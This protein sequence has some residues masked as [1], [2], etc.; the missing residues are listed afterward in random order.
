VHAP[1]PER[2]PVKTA[3][4]GE[5]RVD[6]YAWLRDKTDP[7]LRPHLE[8]ENAYTAATMAGAKGLE[9][10][11]YDEM[12]GRILQT[13]MSAPAPKGDWEYYQR[14][15][16]GKEYPV[17]C[18]RPRGGTDADEGVLV[19]GN[20][21]AE[22]HDYLSLGTI[23]TSPDGHLLAYS[24]DTDGSEA[25]TVRFRDLRTGEALADAIPGTKWSLCWCNDGS[26]LYTVPDATDRPYRVMR[27]VLGTA[28]EDDTLVLEE[29][30][31]RFY[32]S[33]SRGLDGRRMLIHSGGKTTTE[34][35]WLDADDPASGLQV[36][37]PREE[38]VLAYATSAGDVLYVRTNRDATEFVVK[39]ATP[40]T[41]HTAWPDLL[42]YDAAVT[43]RSVT[44]LA[45]HV[46]L[47]ERYRGL[48]RLR[49]IDRA[50]HDVRMLT[51]DEPA[52][53]LSASSN[54]EYDTTTFRF[55]YSSLVTPRTVY[56]EDLA[57][58]AR[59]QRKQQP[60]LG[61]DPTKYRVHRVWATVADG[62]RV[63]I[64]FAARADLPRNGKAP[65]LLYGYGSYGMPYDPSFRSSWVSL[66]DR[67]LV[68]GI[69]HIRGGGDM[70]RA[71]YEA[72]KFETKALTFSDFV[73]CAEYLKV[74]QWVGPVVATGGSAGG[75][76]MGAVLNLRPALWAGILAK[77]PFVDALNTMLDATLPLTV[78][79]YD[80]WG[81]PEEE[82]IYT[83]MKAYSPYDNV[84]TAPH[85]PVLATG[86]LNDPRVGYWEPAKWVASLRDH[87]TSDH[88]ILFK[89]NLGAGHGGASGRYEYLRELAF[90][91]AWVATTLEVA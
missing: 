16:E 33:V 10:T 71:W 27:H 4:H 15:L 36:L 91:Y 38:G 57:T 22:G 48:D 86:G 49:V 24:V 9:D 58:A 6:E 64:S 56:D 29:P 61:Y 88:P 2:R 75:L 78:T 14:T 62:T 82:N 80:E 55:A 50:T 45:S 89:V 53:Q 43:V 17:Y 18:R 35:A 37:V 42:P 23:A 20:A 69:A 73:S 34:V 25:Y 32:V 30:D 11:L 3:L 44:A 52:F 83:A 51:F 74:H 46:V 90:E 72:A 1:R 12:V 66:L 87:T 13:D 70:G 63:P 67:G 28:A 54:L 7:A 40:G 85:P 19:D 77:V 59:V 68:V 47:G 31:G 5:V 21:L 39:V 79:E 60:V 84:A 26:V 76:L 8:A 41:A 65:C 81:N